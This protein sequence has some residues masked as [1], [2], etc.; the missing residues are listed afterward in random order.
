VAPPPETVLI[1]DDEEAIRYVL[2]RELALLG[3]ESVA[4]SSGRE[5]LQK[6]ESQSFAVVMLDA[7]MPGI[8]GL[9]VLKRARADHLDT[10]F[11]MLSA[12][13]DTDI[14]ATASRLGADDFLTKPWDP[15]DLG[16]RLD[17]AKERRALARQNKGEQPSS[18]NAASGEKEYRDITKDLIGQQVT[19]YER[20]ASR[21]EPPAKT[22]RSRR[23]WPWG[24]KS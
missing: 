8:S 24:R 3:Y 11:L 18:E 6:L 5:A 15:D 23:W 19:F 9:E 14:A 4:V 12:L 2:A 20:L 10:C 7:R 13:V 1:V 21:S 17:R 16:F 22:R